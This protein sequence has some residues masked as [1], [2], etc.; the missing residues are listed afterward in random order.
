MG[1]T[2]QRK[3]RYVK[4]SQSQPRL[5]D[6]YFWA[7]ES[8]NSKL[9]YICEKPQKNIGCVEG[10][11]ENYQGI[12]DRGESGVKCQPW[13]SPYLS[14]VLDDDKIKNLGDLNTNYCRNPDGDVAP[15]CIAP[16]GEFDYCD[17]PKCQDDND[18]II[19]VSEVRCAPDKFQ[20]QT[21]PLECVVSAFVCDGF[22]DCSNGADEDKCTGQASLESFE[23]HGNSR[24]DVHYVERWLNTTLKACA[25]HCYSSKDFKCRSFNYQAAKRLCI[26]NEENI[27][28]TGKLVSDTDWDYYELTSQTLNCG[29]GLECSNGKCLKSEQLCDGK[30]D[31]GLTDD[32]D[33][34]NCIKPNIKVR[35]SG[36]TNPGEGFIEIKAFNYSYGGVCDDGFGIEEANVICRMAGFPLGAKK[37]H[38]ASTLGNGRGDIILD[39]LDC[40]GTETSILDCKFQPWTKHDCRITEWAGVTCNLDTSCSEEVIIVHAKAPFMI[41][42]F[43]VKNSSFKPFLGNEM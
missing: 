31:C 7:L 30:N 25:S 34:R 38:I 43:H 17:I 10:N 28:M 3:F 15:W 40:K 14:M 16:N 19:D 42:C 9:P 21:N 1:I 39:E 35:L 27:G 33:E 11:G 6:Y 26:L 37:A 23:K 29:T 41:N 4:P 20:C 2:M 8:L 12:A 32:T 36:S 24:L 22:V 13:N 5:I 18:D